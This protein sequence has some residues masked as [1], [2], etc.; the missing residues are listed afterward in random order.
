MRRSLSFSVGVREVSKKSFHAGM[1]PKIPPRSE[2]L[3]SKRSQ[4]AS[5]WIRAPARNW[6]RVQSRTC[7]QWS[8]AFQECKSRFQRTGRP[9]AV[10]SWAMK[11]RSS[12]PTS[13]TAFGMKQTTPRRKGLSA[14]ANAM[15]SSPSAQRLGTGRPSPSKWTGPYED[16]NPKAPA[17]MHSATTSAIA[18]ISSAVAARLRASSPITWY[19]IVECG[20]RD[21]TLTPSP[22]SRAWRYSP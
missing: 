16:E 17:S 18:W 20:A 8:G 5:G 7:R 21:M 11:R 22:R 2:K 9:L 6:L 10:E 12:A 1:S 3:R 14:R 13:G 19:R 4:S 15:I